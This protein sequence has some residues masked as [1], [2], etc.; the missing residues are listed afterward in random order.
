MFQAPTTRLTAV[1]LLALAMLGG[2]AMFAL[3]QIGS[4]RDQ[5]LQVNDRNR[6]S[7]LQLLR[8]QNTLN[9]LALSAR[10]MSEGSGGYPISAY[11][12]QVDRLLL[13]LADALRQEREL[14]PAE[15]LPAQ[16]D[17]LEQQAASLQEAFHLALRLA[18]EGN[19]GDARRQ[20]LE[21]V[22]RQRTSLSALVSRL[23]V[24][25]NEAEER[26][27]EDTL[28]A[29]RRAEETLLV[30]VGVMAIV[31]IA[32]AIAALRYNLRT[33]RQL[34]VL[35]AERGGLTQA[36]IGMQE[37]ILRSVSRELHD[38]FGQIL[39][40]VN[41][42]LQRLVR[43]PQLAESESLRDQIE[44]TR[45]A[46]REALERVRDLSQMLHPALIE[47]HGLPGAI[48]RYLAGFER[49]NGIRVHTNEISLLELVPDD[50]AIHVYRIVQEA[51][52]NVS[53]HSGAV[54]AWLRVNLKGGT[55]LLEVEDDGVGIRPGI[56]RRD[57]VEWEGRDVNNRSAPAAGG[58]GLIAMR[59]R[60]ALLGGDF[61]LQ[62]TSAGAMVRVRLPLGL[63]DDDV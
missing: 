6:R 48:E 31:M 17:L 52:S 14:S 16:N 25:N 39:T 50:Q 29:Y 45:V 47:S 61:C 40:A 33:Q 36:M 20:L 37:G 57:G 7:T 35:S 1:F 46:T 9:S 27:I 38:D 28:A 42:T 32:F 21:G 2:F 5:Q 60:T 26:S 22:Y 19:Q 59:E 12:P 44:E 18:E 10:D 24:Q 51:L 30:F 11:R 58:L 41:A 34:E 56:Q 15:R 55:L 13:D 63:E 3:W 4:L 43:S 62:N 8:I 49:Q 23:L 53:R 54:Q